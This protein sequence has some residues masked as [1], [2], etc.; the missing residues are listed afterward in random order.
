MDPISAILLAMAVA[1]YF[2]KNIY[3]DSVFK[4]R[5]Q[6]P[7]S[8]RRQQERAQRRAEKAN[9]VSVGERQEARRFW[10]NAWEDAWESADEQR[11]RRRA[12]KLQERRRRWADEDLAYAEDEAYERNR[13][14]DEAERPKTPIP[15]PAPIP[16]PRPAAEGEGPKPEPGA[17][18][19]DA[20]P[21]E[22][23]PAEQPADQPAGTTP[24]G[25]TDDHKP[26]TEGA[27]VFRPDVWNRPATTTQEDPS[28]SAESHNLAAALAYTNDMATQ[29]DAA[30]ASTETSIAGMTAGGV[31]GE[32]ITAMHAAQEA[33]AQAAAQFRNAH[34]ELERHISIKEAYNANQGAGE[35]QYVTSE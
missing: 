23:K 31:T 27:T 30:I 14:R 12:K 18:T 4:A 22:T 3:Q 24:P 5:G 11:A 34:A 26:D 28:M 8:Y 1:G 10:V 35:K 2:T 19:E 15:A 6:D 29:S 16:A 7:P 20:K 33:L 9:R 13:A 32:A 25:P 21:D 17:S